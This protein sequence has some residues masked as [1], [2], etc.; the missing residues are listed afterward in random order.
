MCCLPNRFP[1]PIFL[2]VN[3]FDE[4]G[5]YEN[6]PWLENNQI[7]SYVEENQFIKNFYISTSE[8]DSCCIRESSVSNHT[9]PLD[10]PLREMINTILKFKDIRQ[11]ILKIP[12]DKENIENNQ[13]SKKCFI[14]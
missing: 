12:L 2:L 9:V 7:K 13:S 8:K 5:K 4:S 1:L 6:K 3:K 14:L 11:Q 10:C